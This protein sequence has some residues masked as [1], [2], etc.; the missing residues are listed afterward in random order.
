MVEFFILIQVFSFLSMGVM[1]NK[2]CT[3]QN[4]LEIITNKQKEVHDEINR[5]SKE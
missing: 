2:I 1:M 4:E 5:L 3:L